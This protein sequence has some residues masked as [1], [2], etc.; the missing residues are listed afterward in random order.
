MERSRSFK[1]RE[2]YIIG[3]MPEPKVKGKLVVEFYG[4]RDGCKTVNMITGKDRAILQ[5]C[6]LGLANGL[7]LL[8]FL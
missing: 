6:G 5:L 4:F 3:T 1:V 2:M 8:A 7:Y